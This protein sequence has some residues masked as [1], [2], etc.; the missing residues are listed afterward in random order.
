MKRFIGCAMR[1]I[2][3]HKLIQVEDHAAYLH[4][5]CLLVGLRRLFLKESPDRRPLKL[6]WRPTQRQSVSQ[7]KLPFPVA[8]GLAR[9]SLS[10][11]LG[12]PIDEL[13]VEQRQGLRRDGC[14]RPPLGALRGVAKVE[15][16]EHRHQERP[17]DVRINGPPVDGRLGRRLP[18][19]LLVGVGLNRG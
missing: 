6:R 9:K 16:F 5:C 1:S 17:L 13:A 15:R 3:I 19:G 4:Q 11:P 18:R 14:R 2:R 7:L 12:L 10:K 8:A